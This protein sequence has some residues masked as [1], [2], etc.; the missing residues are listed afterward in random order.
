MVTVPPLFGSA[1]PMTNSSKVLCTY[2]QVWPIQTI[3]ASLEWAETPEWSAAAMTPS[4]LPKMAT[5]LFLTLAQTD[6]DYQILATPGALVWRRVGRSFR[7]QPVNMWKTRTSLITWVRNP[8][9]SDM[10]KG[11]P[12]DWV[13]Q[14]PNHPEGNSAYEHPDHN[15]EHSETHGLPSGVWPST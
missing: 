13:C 4:S 3:V 10:G 12:L 8:L 9:P 7:S 5:E 6:R 2:N 14:N 1:F 15:Y 11:S